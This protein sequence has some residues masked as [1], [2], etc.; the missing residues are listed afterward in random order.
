MK[1]FIRI[2]MYEVHKVGRTDSRNL[3]DL[4]VFGFSRP[5]NLKTSR[6]VEIL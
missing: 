4:V 5:E 6:L 3:K 2:A 1:N